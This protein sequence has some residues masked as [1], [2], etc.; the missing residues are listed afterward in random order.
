MGQDLTFVRLFAPEKLHVSPVFNGEG[1][2]PPSP[3]S[4]IAIENLSHLPGEADGLLWHSLRDQ[5]LPGAVTPM[6]IAALIYGEVESIVTI[7]W[8]VLGTAF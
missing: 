8:I 5:D 4:G 2:G 3:G 7:H 1:P 6:Q